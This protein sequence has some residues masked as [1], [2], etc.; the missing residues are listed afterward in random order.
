MQIILRGLL[1]QATMEGME[2]ISFMEQP[3]P[4]ASLRAALIIFST[5]PILIVYPFIQ[6]YFVKGI[7]IGGVKG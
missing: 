5:V 3:P 4:G 7:M 2:N 1:N 6:R